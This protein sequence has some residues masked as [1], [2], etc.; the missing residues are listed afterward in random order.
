MVINGQTAM[1]EPDSVS[2]LGLLGFISEDLR[3]RGRNRYV[4][5]EDQPSLISMATL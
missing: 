5:V 1:L 2:L 4:G 3:A